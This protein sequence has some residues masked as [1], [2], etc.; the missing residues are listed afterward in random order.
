MG[1]RTGL[2]KEARG[3]ILCLC[4]GLNPRHPVCS[5]DTTL[6]SGVMLIRYERLGKSRTTRVAI[7]QGL[8]HLISVTHLCLNLLQYARYVETSSYKGCRNKSYK[9]NVKVGDTF[10]HIAIATSMAEN[11][12]HGGLGYALCYINCAVKRKCVCVC[13][14]VCEYFSQGQHQSVPKRSTYP[15]TRLD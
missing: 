9:Y 3:K 4:W 13:V 11:G 10:I 8:S 15:L 2:D 12:L 6:S 7:L 5:Q 14:C 1:L